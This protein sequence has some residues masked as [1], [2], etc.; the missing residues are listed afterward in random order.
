MCYQREEIWLE[1]R[2][3]A[4]EGKISG[5]ELLKVGYLVQKRRRCAYK[6]KIFG[7]GEDEDV[8]TKG[9]CLVWKRKKCGNKEKIFGLE[10]TKCANKGQIFG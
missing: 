10:K 1:G 6:E 7:L 3:C 2:K 8:L 5:L 9:G 4:T